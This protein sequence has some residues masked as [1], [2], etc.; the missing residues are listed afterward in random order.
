MRKNIEMFS[1][2]YRIN[3]NN[4]RSGNYY[5]PSF[6]RIPMTLRNS[7]MY[8]A[9]KNWHDIPLNI[10]N[11]ISLNSFKKKYKKFLL[12]VPQHGDLINNNQ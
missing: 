2:N 5:A 8:R 3:L 4:T 7:I 11:S 12:S 9:P 1:Q 10:R 6:Q